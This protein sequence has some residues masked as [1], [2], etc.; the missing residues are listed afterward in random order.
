MALY[1][2]FNDVMT[3]FDTVSREELWER[4]STQTRVPSEIAQHTAAATYLSD[5]AE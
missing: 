5:R 2:P 4:T 3:A 1:A